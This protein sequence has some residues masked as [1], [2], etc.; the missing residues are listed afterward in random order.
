MTN[1]CKD[2]SREPVP[3]DQRKGWVSLAALWIASMIC[4]PAFMMGVEMGHLTTIPNILL[5]GV[6]VG[7]FSTILS[8]LTGIVT[9]SCHMGVGQILRVTFGNQASKIITLILALNL[10]FWFAIQLEFFAQGIHI[11]LK[12]MFEIHVEKHIL[13]ILGGIVMTVT[14]AIGYKALEKLSYISA[15]IMAGVLLWPLLSL[16]HEISLTTPE[17]SVSLGVITSMY[18]GGFAAG[19]TISPDFFRYIKNWKHSA[20]GMGVTFVIFT[21]LMFSLLASYAGATNEKDIFAIFIALGIGLPA[22]AMIILSAWT[23]NDTNL[24][25]ASLNLSAIIT[26][27]KKWFIACIAGTL[28]TILALFGILS[29]FMTLLILI[30]II[31]LPITATYVTDFFFHKEKYK[32]FTL[33]TIRFQSWIGFLIGLGVG[34]STLPADQNG[35][36][37]LTLTTISPIDGLVATSLTL[38]ILNFIGAKSHA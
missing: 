7:V 17:G 6:S 3:A 11:A 22:I 19:L 21:P 36:G 5:I 10:F 26:K 29:Q 34:M 30:G 38:I 33:E 28:G 16:N 37:L 2:Y 25:S 9:D 18:I 15:P 31:M 8:A 27:G 32:N 20:I 23:T 12:N 14:G 1:F 13:I 4:V 35:F 24:Y